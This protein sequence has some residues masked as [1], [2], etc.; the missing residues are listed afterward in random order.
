MLLVWPAQGLLLLLV[1]SAGGCAERNWFTGPDNCNHAK[2]QKRVLDSIEN[3][4]GTRRHRLAS[5]RAPGSR[6]TSSPMPRKNSRSR[7]SQP[8]FSPCASRS[9]ANVTPT[10]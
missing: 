6:P 2:V 4:P 9:A 1:L 3:G 10:S 7:L 8:S 5:G